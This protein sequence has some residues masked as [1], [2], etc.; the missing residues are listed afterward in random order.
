MVVRIRD[1]LVGRVA[2][3]HLGGDRDAAAVGEVRRLI[4]REAPPP[5]DLLGD[6]AD[7]RAAVE[8]RPVDRRNHLQEHD[9]GFLGGRE[10]EPILDRLACFGRAVGRDQDRGHGRMIRRETAFGIGAIADLRSGEVPMWPRPALTAALEPFTQRVERVA[11][12]RSRSLLRDMEPGGNLRDLLGL[13]AQAEM[14][15]DDH[16]LPARQRVDGVVHRS[17]LLVL[18]GLVLRAACRAVADERLQRRAVLE[19]GLVE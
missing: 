19:H 4:Q 9:A 15:A 12:D 18:D 1:D 14:P 3:E 13:A 16:P 6:R 5:L 8:L 17:R 11:L 7:H 10:L 2:G